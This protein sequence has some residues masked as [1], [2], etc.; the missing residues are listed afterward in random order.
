MSL[1]ENPIISNFFVVGAKATKSSRYC[2][3]DDLFLKIALSGKVLNFVVDFIIHRVFLI[4]PFDENDR[5]IETLMS[6]RR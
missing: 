5:L 2:K 6:E 3:R 4:H 1:I